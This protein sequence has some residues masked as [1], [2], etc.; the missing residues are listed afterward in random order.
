MR[1]DQWVQLTPAKLATVE[2]SHLAAVDDNVV[3]AS[4]AQ[5]QDDYIVSVDK[6]ALS[7]VTGIRLE[8]FPDASHQGG[9]LA[10]SDDGEFILTNLKVRV[11]K[12]GST[13][14]RDV[15]LASAVSD[16]DGKAKDAKYAGIA[17]TTCPTLQGA[18]NAACRLRCVCARAV[19]GLTCA[20]C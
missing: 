16:F 3:Q 11:R 17:Q 20:S 7:R 1:S 9:G 18:A 19:A 15:P 5:F 8:V 4:N 6:F 10:H 12:T 13:Q 2:G 14:I